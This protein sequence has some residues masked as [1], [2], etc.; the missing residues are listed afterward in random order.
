MINIRY[1]YT[2]IDVGVLSEPFRYREALVSVDKEARQLRLALAD[3]LASGT[4]L[5]MAKGELAVLREAQS[6][7]TERLQADTFIE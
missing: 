5:S 4:D 3:A 6:A 2:Y 7:A 1:T